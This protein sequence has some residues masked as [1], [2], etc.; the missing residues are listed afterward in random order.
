MTLHLD[1]K[2][3]RLPEATELSIFRIVQEGLTMFGVMPRLH[4]S[5]FP[6]SIRLRE[7]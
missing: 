7:L 2:L 5:I 3:G 6:L 1:M 4:R